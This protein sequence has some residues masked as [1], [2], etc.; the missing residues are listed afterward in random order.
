MIDQT[1]KS[2]LTF[3]G[4]Y[5]LENPQA[6]LVLKGIGDEYFGY[7]SDG[8]HAYMV[9]GEMNLDYLRLTIEEGPDR[10]INY[11]SLDENFNLMV[12]D[13]QLKVVYFTRSS[14]SVEELI[15]TF[16]KRRASEKGE[17]TKGVSCQQKVSS[18]EKKL[19][20]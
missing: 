12:T 15:T 8:H 3:E 20:Q 4:V 9:I 11:L 18:V 14:E 6:V 17:K 16:E 5:T 7:I 1:Q 13:K 10:A 2:K 19:G